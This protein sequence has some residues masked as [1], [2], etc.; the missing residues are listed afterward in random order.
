MGPLLKASFAFSRKRYRVL[1]PASTRIEACGGK[2]A[3]TLPEATSID[4]KEV[5]LEVIGSRGS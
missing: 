4:H 3:F 2:Y 5:S 1:D